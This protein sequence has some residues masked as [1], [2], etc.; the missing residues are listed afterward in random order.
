MREG[1]DAR[2]NCLISVSVTGGSGRR[3]VLIC[4]DANVRSQL[5]KRTPCLLRAR[6]HLELLNCYVSGYDGT[7]QWKISTRQDQWVIVI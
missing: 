3:A 6:D 7:Q 4:T 2:A 1:P 5:T